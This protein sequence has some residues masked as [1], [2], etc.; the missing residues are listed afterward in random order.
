MKLEGTFNMD[1]NNI[2]TYVSL[3]KKEKTRRILKKCSNSKQDI[4]FQAGQI[5]FARYDS[6]QVVSLN[7]TIYVSLIAIFIIIQLHSCI[8]FEIM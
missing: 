2:I 3:Y 5:I 8:N 6:T 7:I 4:L 1:G